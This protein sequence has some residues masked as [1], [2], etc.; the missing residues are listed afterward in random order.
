MNKIHHSGLRKFAAFAMLASSALVP[1]SR[2]TAQSSTNPASGKPA[3]YGL[4][5]NTA[6]SGVVDPDMPDRAA[7][8]KAW[9]K[10]PKD[11]KQLEI[12]WTEITLGN[13]WF[14]DLIRTAKRVAAE[15]GMSLD[16]EV[17][18]GDLQRQCSQIDTFITKKVD[19]IVVDPTDTL[20][21]ASCINRA[22]SAG[23]PVVAIGTVPEASSRILT[24]ITPNP[25]ENG[26]QSGRYIAKTAGNTPIVAGMII[27]VVGN[28]T[29]ESRIDGML[30]GIVFERS[31]AG[32]HP[33]SREDAMLHGFR[34]FQ[35]LKKDG[36]FDDP[37][38]RFKILAIG[39][40][41]WTQQGG[42]S[43]AEDMLS[44]H[45][46]QLNMIMADNDF[47]AAGAFK[48]I[49]NIGKNGT[50]K[51]AACSDGDRVALEQIKKGNLLVTG[52]WSPEDTAASTIAFLD[53]IY[54]HG[55]DPSNLP[56]GSYFKA[57]A[58]TPQ[59]VDQFIDPDTDNQF[60][61]YSITPVMTIPQVRATARG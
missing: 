51:V 8:N 32:A 46:D 25:Y 9:P 48:A 36:H 49:R 55:F 19:T 7:I 27:G 60:Y 39:E 3:I 38:S 20:G 17:A 44:A 22:V 50:I 47:M 13:P 59:N 18:D 24:T 56:M 41:H 23:I 37:Q 58:I 45:A 11:P 30:G 31:Q 61:K 35:Q 2:A 43:A 21:V 16:V 40:G 33:M 57:Y 42:L 4:L 1:A 28:S 26:F 5:P 54:R 52:T 10:T 12:G 34:L 53:N 14:V 15:K 6:L 29:A